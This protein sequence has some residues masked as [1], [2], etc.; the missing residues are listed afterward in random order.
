MVCASAIGRKFD[1]VESGLWV[2]GVGWQGAW[3]CGGRQ[4]GCNAQINVFRGTKVDKD[5]FIFSLHFYEKF[6]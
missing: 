6:K 2:G 4:G 3:V 1:R 5:L